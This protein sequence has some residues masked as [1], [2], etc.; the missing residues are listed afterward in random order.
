MHAEANLVGYGVCAR[1]GAGDVVEAVGHGGV[2]H[3]VAGV[4][5]VR[6]YGGDLYLDLVS[7]TGR[8]GV[9]THPGEQLSDFLG[10]FAD[11][12]KENKHCSSWGVIYL[13]GDVLWSGWSGWSFTEYNL[14][15]W[16]RSYQITRNNK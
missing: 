1:R 5:D 12:R 8:L 7:V 6:A 13:C 9:Q 15:K 11:R 4:D 2:L 10:R 3:D 16:M 14:K